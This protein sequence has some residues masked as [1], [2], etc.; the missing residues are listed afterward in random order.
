MVAAAVEAGEKFGS[1]TVSARKKSSHNL[2][3]FWLPAR[4]AFIL[5]MICR[6]GW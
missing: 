5:G 2:V 3:K 1:L 6:G 4:P